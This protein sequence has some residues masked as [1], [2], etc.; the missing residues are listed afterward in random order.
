M[1]TNG[2]GYQLYWWHLQQISLWWLNYDNH[3]SSCAL[4]NSYCL[5]LGFKLVY[6]EYFIVIILQSLHI[7]EISKISTVCTWIKKESSAVHLRGKC[8]FNIFI[9]TILYVTR[10]F[11]QLFSMFGI[12]IFSHQNFQEKIHNVQMLGR[13]MRFTR[14]RS[15]VT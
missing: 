7:N 3:G 6:E 1:L 14:S 8:R 12:F 5:G 15:S 13:K 9:H 2:S 4:Y 11:S 10:S